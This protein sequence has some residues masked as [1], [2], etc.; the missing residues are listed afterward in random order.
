MNVI[1]NVCEVKSWLGGCST[2]SFPCFSVV[3]SPEAYK[4]HN[5][6]Q[7]IQ[8]TKELYIKKPAFEKG[9]LRFGMLYHRLQQIRLIITKY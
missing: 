8:I 9:I 7:S 5:L 6:W 2:G 4:N 3:G 1:W